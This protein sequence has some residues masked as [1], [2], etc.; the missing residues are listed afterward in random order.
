MDCKDD[1]STESY[2]FYYAEASISWS[3]RKQD[4]VAP[5]STVAEYV[6]LDGAVREALYLMKALNTVEVAGGT[7]SN[8]NLHR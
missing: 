3:S 5:S 2:I 6:T 8:S 1:E 7:N 4:L